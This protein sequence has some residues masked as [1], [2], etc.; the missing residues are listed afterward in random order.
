MKEQR[1][2]RG[3]VWNVPVFESDKKRLQTQFLTKRL[4]GQKQTL[5]QNPHWSDLADPFT[6]KDMEKAVSRIKTAL[7][8]QERIMVFGDFDADGITA[9][10]ALVHGLQTL[11]AKVSYRIPDRV[12]HS[13]G[14]KKDLIKEIVQTGSKLIITVDCG[15]NDR[16]EV[17]FAQTLGLEVIIT[18][19][20]NVD[21]QRWANNALAVLNPLRPDCNFPSPNLAGVGVVFKLLQ[22]LRNDP[23]FWK[24]YAAL[25]AIGSVADCVKLQG[26]MRTLVQ[27]GLIELNKNHWPGVLALL[28]TDDPIDAE[29]I[30]FTLAPCLNAA[31]RLGQVQPAVQLF[32]G[33]NRQTSERVIYLK[34]LNQQRRELS[35]V[36]SAQAQSLV[37]G[38]QAVQIIF[39]EA[40]PVGVLGLVASRLVENL[41]QP[42]MVLTRHPNGV[43]HGSARAP[44][45]FH[46][47]EALER[48]NHLL[49]AYGGH[50]GAAGFQLEEAFLAEFIS[51]MQTWFNT[52]EALPLTLN[53]AGQVEPHWLDLEWRQWEQSLEPFGMG[54][55]KPVWYL[56]NLKLSRLATLGKSAQ[57]ARLT[58][59]EQYE[60][61]AFFVEDIIDQLELG[62]AYD[63]AVKVSDN[64]W[65][66]RKK[67][68]WQLVDIKAV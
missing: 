54:N 34:Q 39:L 48:V 56:R 15:V 60:V 46:L 53:L 13:H 19:H 5:W 24:P 37:V 35:Q 61:V 27:L 36:Y 30:A 26:E 45:N 55:L 64:T 68:Q 59:S 7:D 28:E 63:L 42:I 11:G 67:V 4:G 3:K 12:R 14:L 43:L 62:K 51:T 65:N 41:A 1:S 23:D 33:D 44:Q 20:H 9:T 38:Q 49:M 40:C 21:G 8:Q 16:E 17:A 58:F 66:G 25:V 2:L 32:L 18:D 29:T 47:A 57:H 52:K 31:S 50:A 22:A 10:A 6:L